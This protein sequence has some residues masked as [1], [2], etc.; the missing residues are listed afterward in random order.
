V[1]VR[2]G[3][4][5]AAILAAMFAPKADAKSTIVR[6]QTPSKNIGCIYS[7]GLGRRTY[8]RC[9]ILSGLR[10]EPKRPCPVDWTGFSMTA[11]SRATATCAGDTTYDRAARIVPYGG[12]WHQRGFACTIRRV[13]LRCRNATG[14]GFFLSRT[15]SYGF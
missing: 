5:L 15:R 2:F 13:G 4:V 12:T 3:L 9:D 10:P 7:A 11:K 14:H 8:L 1:I 6:F